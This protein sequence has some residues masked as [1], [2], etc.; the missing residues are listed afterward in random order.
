MSDDHNPCEPLIYELMDDTR[1]LVL[2]PLCFSLSAILFL[3]STLHSGLKSLIDTPGPV[4]L[5][6]SI[7]RSFCSKQGSPKIS[8]HHWWLIWVYH[9]RKPLWFLLIIYMVYIYIS[10]GDVSMNK[11]I[12][13]MESPIDQE[14]IHVL[15]FH[16]CMILGWLASL[17]FVVGYLKR[18][19]IG[20]VE[21]WMK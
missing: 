5:V 14:E 2:V 9:A 21:L 13:I 10:L 1:C 12:T 15:F 17:L 16:S 18:K 7:L 20:K 4:W 3:F 19:H 6:H 11:N 8:K